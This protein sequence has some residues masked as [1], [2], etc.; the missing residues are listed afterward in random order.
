MMQATT[1]TNPENMILRKRNQTP[2]AVYCAP[3][4]ASSIQSR[5]IYGGSEQTSRA[6]ARRKSASGSRQVWGLCWVM[7]GC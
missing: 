4:F 7:T 1:D 5:Q 3:A 6:G 2:P